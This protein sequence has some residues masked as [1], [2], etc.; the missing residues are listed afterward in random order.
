MTFRHSLAFAIAGFLT[1]S[2]VPAKPA[3]LGVVMAAKLVHL[4]TTVVT[5][6]A[7]IFD[8]DRF[9]TE[10]GGMLRLRS[11]TA[12]IELG[13]ESAVSFRSPPADAQS[14][15]VRLDKGR[16]VFSAVRAA[17]IE[18]IACEA[19]VR[20][21]KDGRT[22]A[23]VKVTGPSELRIDARRGALQFSFRG[24]TEK[25]TEGRSY[26]VILDPPNNS[27]TEKG[28]V[29]PPK[30]FK[31]VLIGEGAAVVALGIYELREPESPDRP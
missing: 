6:G 4:N 24:E 23:Q 20:P 11:G 13:E 28:P 18:I 15:E 8:G 5:A 2:S 10:T 26:R 21:S 7:T 30:G 27:P 29:H 31:I 1:L 12:I 14:V 22:V 16:L 3:L 17:S 25:L 19:R 9:S